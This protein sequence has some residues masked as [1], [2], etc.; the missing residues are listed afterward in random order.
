MERFVIM[1]VVTDVET[2]TF[3]NGNIA[4]KVK[5]LHPSETQ[6]GKENIYQVEFNYG[7]VKQIPTNIELKGATVMVIGSLSSS[8]SKNGALLNFLKGERLSIISY[9]SFE[10]VDV[11]TQDTVSYVKPRYDYDVT[12]DDLPF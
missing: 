10:E 2:T 7:Y 11:N 6:N 3:V 5:I 4:K 9:P 12:D 1:G 8:Q